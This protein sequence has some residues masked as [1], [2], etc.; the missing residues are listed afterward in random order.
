MTINKDTTSPGGTAGF[1]LKVD[2]VMRWINASHRVELRKC[3][4][5][6]LNYSPAHYPHKDLNPSRVLQDEWDNQAIVDVTQTL[7]VSP[8]SIS[9]LVCISNGMIATKEVKDDLLSAEKER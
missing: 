3:L 6:Y 7:F 4:Y 2:A 1:S 9:E 8:F 5:P